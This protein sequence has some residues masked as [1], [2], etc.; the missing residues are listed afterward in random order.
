LAIDINPED[1][2][3]YT[4]Q[5][6]EAFLKYVENEYCAKHRRMSVTKPE[7]HQHSNIFPSANVA[8]FGQSSFDPYDS[9]SDDDEYLTPKCVAE[10]SPGR[11]DRAARL[12]TAPR[13]YSNSPPESPKNWGQVNPNVI[14]YHS[15]PME[16][17]STFWLTDIT[18]WWRQQKETHSKYADLSNVACDIFSIIPHGVRVEARFSLGRDVIGWRQSKTTGETLREKVVV[19]QFARANNGILA[20]DCAVLDT[21]ETENAL[22]LKTVAD[23]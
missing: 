23:E 22:E 20:G 4:T 7:N 12:L 8:G 17:S 21:T 9:S 14:D 6:Q 10:T 15:D 3:S 5:Y 2:M 18:D 16:I 13:L 19:R 11:G 1:E